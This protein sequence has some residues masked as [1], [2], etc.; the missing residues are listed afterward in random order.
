MVDKSHRLDI[1]HCHSELDGIRIANTWI[2]Q[3]GVLFQ[4]FQD[5]RKLDHSGQSRAG[6]PPNV[7]GI[8]RVQ[9][10]LVLLPR[11]IEATGL[12]FFLTRKTLP[13]AMA[14]TSR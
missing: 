5:V 3:F 7:L 6:E 14:A 2:R 13:K 8:L 1:I 9:R 4:N 11:P 10:R 12:R